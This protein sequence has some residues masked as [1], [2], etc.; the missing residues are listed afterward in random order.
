MRNNAKWHL[1]H[2]HW[3]YPSQLVDSKNRKHIICV[4]FNC[5]ICICKMIMYITL[6]IKIFI[7]FKLKII[8]FNCPICFTEL[9]TNLKKKK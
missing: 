1:S 4:S 2:K 5:S 7:F 9:K 8:I 3:K 6:E